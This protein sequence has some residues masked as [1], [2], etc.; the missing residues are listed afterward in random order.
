[1][2]AFIASSVLARSTANP[3]ASSVPTRVA[4]TTGTRAFAKCRRVADSLSARDALGGASRVPS[5]TSTPARSTVRFGVNALD[6]AMPFDNEAR[7]AKRLRKL[8]I[9][10]VGFG[11]FGQFLAKRFIDNDHAVIATSRGDY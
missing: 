8:K 10:I 9:W 5:R 2:S 6:A 1:M 7:A 3:R 11:N 4:S